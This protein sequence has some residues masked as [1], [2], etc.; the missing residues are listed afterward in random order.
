MKIGVLGGT[1]DPVHTGHIRMAESCI[2]KMGLDRIMF[3]PN[4]NPPHKTDKCI[5]DK[6]HRLNMIRIAIEDYEKFFLCDYE[7]NREDYSYSVETM[8]YLRENYDH[9]LYLIIGADSF[10]QI[11]KWYC[12]K[13]LIRENSIIVLDRSY[14]GH[15][16]I[17]KDITEFNHIYDAD[18]HLCVMPLVDISSTDI[19]SKIC[20]GEDIKGLVPD[21]VYDYI[22][23]NKLYKG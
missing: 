6:Y 16:G 10:Y 20:G 8:R 13:D 11:D 22:K 17:V 15:E 7:I 2:R 23:V 3:L 21:G 1:F 5:T 12:Y 4:G 18:V 14:Q 19:R 9:K